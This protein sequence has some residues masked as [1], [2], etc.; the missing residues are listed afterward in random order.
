M[1]QP[2][3]KNFLKELENF[4]KKKI[5]NKSPL[6]IYSSIWQSCLY[7]RITPK[8]F[9]DSLIKI[10][11]KISKKNTVLMPSFIRTKKKII[12]LNIEPSSSGYLTNQ[13]MSKNKVK[14]LI[15]PV[16]P[17][18]VLGKEYNNLKNLTS[19]EVWGKNS[20]TEYLY[21]RNAYIFTLGTHPTEC[22][23]SHYAEWLNKEK[24]YY[25]RIKIKNFNLIYNKKNY[26]IKK[27]LF[28]KKENVKYNFKKFY[29]SELKNGME[30]K[31]I[32]KIIISITSAKKKIN[33]I[34]DKLKKNP[35]YLL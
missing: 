10:F 24:I 12:N 17:F 18:L 33:M 35:K 14:R 13:F 4:L 11:V 25:R 3:F 22:S 34:R 20:V 7:F 2:T 6:V 23:L 26:R 31:K 21:K 9:S 19:T 1:T 28:V 15:C 27:K 5:N 16:F 30:T 8:E 32:G 29:K